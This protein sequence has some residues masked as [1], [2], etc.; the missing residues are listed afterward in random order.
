LPEDIDRGVQEVYGDWEPEVTERLREA[1]EECC[2][3]HLRELEDM[4]KIARQAALDEPA[5]WRF[6]NKDSATVDDD[7]A[8]AGSLRFGTRLGSKSV[9]VIPVK[10]LDLTEFRARRHD[11]VKKHFRISDPRLIKLVE[12]T[13]TPPRWGSTPGL[14][15][16]LPLLLDETGHVLHSPVAARLDPD[17]GLVVGEIR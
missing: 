13:P 8:E 14:S 4:K 10:P 11:L 16:H 2:D 15:A 12:D 6:S 1:L 3:A 9:S 5:E 17:L 7:K